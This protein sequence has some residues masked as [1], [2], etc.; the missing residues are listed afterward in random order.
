MSE[1]PKWAVQNADARLTDEELASLAEVM[2]VAELTNS[3]REL[4]DNWMDSRFPRWLIG[5]R[6]IARSTDERSFIAS[7]IPRVGVGHSMPLISTEKTAPI[8]AVLLGLIGSMTFDYVV[9][10]K[11]GGTNMTFGYVK[12][13]P[14][15]TPDTF[16]AAALSYIVPVS[17]N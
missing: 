13:F 11:L 17:S 6:N 4:L 2:N 16:T 10:Q 8:C 3:L 5:F 9:R 12:Q 14:V 15:P 7:A 1:F